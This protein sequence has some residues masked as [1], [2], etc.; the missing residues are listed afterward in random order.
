LDGGFGGRRERRGVREWVWSRSSWE[1]VMQ[2]L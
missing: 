1:V 2:P